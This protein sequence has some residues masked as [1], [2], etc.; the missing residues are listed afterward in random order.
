MIAQKQPTQHSLPLH[1]RR[2]SMP[3]KIQLSEAQ[4]RKISKESSERNAAVLA[5]TKH[6]TEFFSASVVENIEATNKDPVPLP[7]DVSSEDTPAFP[8]TS[9]ENKKNIPDQ[10]SKG[11]E[12]PQPHSTDTCVTWTVKLHHVT[13]T[14]PGGFLSEKSL[15]PFGQLPPCR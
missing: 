2:P 1:T 5:K 15:C 4:K 10:D 9:A 7:D 14:Q 3:Q 13:Q 11:D 8:S 12:S 6:L